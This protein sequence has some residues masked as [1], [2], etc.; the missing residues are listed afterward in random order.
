MPGS[1]S[2]LWRE[3]ILFGRPNATEYDVIAAAQVANAPALRQAFL[4]GL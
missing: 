1:T 2:W 3:N 4:F